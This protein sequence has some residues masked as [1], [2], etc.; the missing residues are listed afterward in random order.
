MKDLG[1]KVGAAPGCSWIQS[2]MRGRIL[3]FELSYWQSDCHL[4][5]LTE[6]AASL[7]GSRLSHFASKF[8]YQLKSNYIIKKT[9]P[10]IHYMWWKMVT[11]NPSQKLGIVFLCQIQTSTR[12]AD[13]SQINGKK[14]KT[15]TKAIWVL[16]V[17]T[18]SPESPTGV[19]WVGISGIFWGWSP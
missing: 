11:C 10:V 4:W 18:S 15:K 17:L 3:C 19:Q 1:H 8:I 6:C 16:G 5:I 9:S 2:A 13:G 12:Q 7:W 14:N